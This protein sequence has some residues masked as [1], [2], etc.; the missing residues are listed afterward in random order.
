MGP[1]ILR[2]LF[3]VQYSILVGVPGLHHLKTQT[4]RAG[5]EKQMSEHLTDIMVRDQ[6]SYN[7][8]EGMSVL[9]CFILLLLLVAGKTHFSLPTPVILDIISCCSIIVEEVDD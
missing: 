5:N 1:K 4:D 3:K 7:Y 2:E 8:P 9:C 6:N